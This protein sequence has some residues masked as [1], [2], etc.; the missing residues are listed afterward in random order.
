MS[1][2]SEREP[3]RMERAAAQ[4]TRALGKPRRAQGPARPLSGARRHQ[5]LL[6]TLEQLFMARHHLKSA[7]PAAMEY[8]G[9]IASLE[10]YLS[11]LETSIA[12]TERALHSGEQS[13]EIP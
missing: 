2:G 11:R 1:E 9:L 6:E 5:L 8:P 10:V 12:S 4:R 7:R 13:A 3:I